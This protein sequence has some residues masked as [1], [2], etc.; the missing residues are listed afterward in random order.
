MEMTLSLRSSTFHIWV[1]GWSTGPSASNSG[2]LLKLIMGD[3]SWCAQISPAY[4]KHPDE[5]LPLGSSPGGSGCWCLILCQH[6]LLHVFCLTS[7]FVTFPKKFFSLS[8][9]FI[10]IFKCFHK[11]LFNSLKALL[12]S[13]WNTVIVFQKIIYIS[14]TRKS[15][16]RRPCPWRN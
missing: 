7:L 12:V 2:F 15:N 9:T 14:W 5:M 6:L 10:F 11:P 13:L 3:S 4:V 16:L 1:P 8:L